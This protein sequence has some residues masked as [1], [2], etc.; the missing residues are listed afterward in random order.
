MKKIWIVDDEEIVCRIAEKALQQQYEIQCVSSGVEALSLYSQEN[1]PDLILMDLNM[2][3]MNGYE[4]ME[5]LKENGAQEIPIIFMTSNEDTESEV[6]GLEMGAKDYIHKP[7]IPDVLLKRVEK[8][9]NNEE[10][11]KVLEKNADTDPLTGLLNRRAIAALVDEYVSVKRQSGVLLMM[12]VDNFK[13]VNDTFGHEAGDR[14]LIRLGE[15]LRPYVRSYDV[16]GRIGGDEFVIFYQEFMNMNALAERC[17]NINARAEFVLNEMLGN[18]APRPVSISIGVACAPED[19]TDFATLYQNADKALYHV[20]Q[21]GKRGYY[22]YEG[23]C[24]SI[25]DVH[26][27]DHAID[28]LQIRMLIEEHSRQPGAYSVSYEDFKKIYRFLKRRS[29]RAET[30]TQFVLFTLQPEQNI[31]ATPQQE[32]VSM[33]RFGDIAERTLRRGDVASQY[34]QNQYMMLLTGTD[35]EKSHIAIDRIIHNWEDTY[36]DTDYKVNYEILDLSV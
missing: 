24:N 17:R 10:M 29:E 33:R 35:Q 34:G 9:I 27:D 14:L 36:H 4:V 23:G 15:I 25:H 30:K 5:H 31:I 22:F 26:A 28:I 1:A 20:K 13:Q 18:K 32:E 6:R 7:F 19:G 11:K 12:D 16:V 8:V 21:N 2:P 3:E